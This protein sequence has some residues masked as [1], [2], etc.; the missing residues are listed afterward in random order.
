MIN[1]L[2]F[3]TL[4]AVCHYVTLKPDAKDLGGVRVVYALSA[5]WPIFVVLMAYEVYEAE[6][7][8]DK[9]SED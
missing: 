2:I 4:I 6:S 8:K 7:E 9:D 1:F 5:F 3:Y